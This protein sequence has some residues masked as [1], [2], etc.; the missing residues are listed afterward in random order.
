MRFS[1]FTSLLGFST[2]SRARPDFRVFMSDDERIAL[3]TAIEAVE[4]PIRGLGW[5]SGGSTIHF[6]RLLPAGS[7]WRAIEHQGKWFKSV[8]TMLKR[9]DLDHVQVQLVEPTHP[10]R[11]GSGDGDEPTFHDYVHFRQA[12]RSCSTSCWSTVA[13]GA[14]ARDRAGDC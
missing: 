9:H 10:H 1:I 11:E 2:G 12:R 8:S 13:Q 6:A 5:D 4:G 7:R 3:E 14:P